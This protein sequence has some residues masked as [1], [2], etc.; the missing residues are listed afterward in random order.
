[1]ADGRYIKKW[2]LEGRKEA[3]PIAYHEWP[4]QGEPG[5]QAW[6][7]WR[8]TIEQCFCGGH[9]A[10]GLLHALGAW[11]NRAPREWQ[12]WYSLQEERVYRQLEGQWHYYSV[13][14]TGQ[15]TRFR[16]FLY[17]GLVEYDEVPDRR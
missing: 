3:N 7:Q 16:R 4:N 13:R 1:M 9:L 14:R 6:M 17:G 10:H 5:R 11:T 2:A 12:W 8:R 15:R